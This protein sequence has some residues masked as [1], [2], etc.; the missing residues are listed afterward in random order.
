MLTMRQQRAETSSEKWLMFVLSQEANA[1][2]AHCTA[3]D[4][5]AWHLALCHFYS[6][7][8]GYGI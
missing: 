7:N 2:Q 5:D 3:W 6:Q 8:D 4:L 1:L